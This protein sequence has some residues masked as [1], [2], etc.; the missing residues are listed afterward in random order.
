MTLFL[1]N[2][3]QK[4]SD[5]TLCEVHRPGAAKCAV[6]VEDVFV[7]PGRGRTEYVV[8]AGIHVIDCCQVLNPL[9]LTY[10]QGCIC[11]R[12]TQQPVFSLV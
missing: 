5:L 1:I 6:P 11:C 8:P 12:V 4:H 9:S 10:A 7:R 3:T 2:F